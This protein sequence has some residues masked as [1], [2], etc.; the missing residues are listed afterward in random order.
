MTV[1]INPDIPLQEGATAYVFR[2]EDEPVATVELSLVN[3]AV[4]ARLVSLTTPGK[5]IQPF[6][7]ILVQL[8]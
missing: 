5:P 2:Q 4:I 6:D 1:Y 7:K 3:G 8:K